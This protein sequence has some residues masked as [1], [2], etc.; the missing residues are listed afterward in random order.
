MIPRNKSDVDEMTLSLRY[1]LAF[2]LKI[3]NC[4]IFYEN[5][6]TIG[7]CLHSSWSAR[8]QYWEKSMN[9]EVKVLIMSYGY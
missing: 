4:R 9:Q 2:S 8:R 6:H 3:Y 1:H 5:P 7:P